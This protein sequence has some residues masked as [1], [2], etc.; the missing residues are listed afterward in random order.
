[1]KIKISFLILLL[2]H[3]LGIFSQTNVMIN[4]GKQWSVMISGMGMEPPNRPVTTKISI[5]QGDSVINGVVYKKIYSTLHEDLSDLTLDGCIRQ[6]GKQ[7]FYL[8]LV[9]HKEILYFDFSIEVGD[10]FTLDGIER[11]VVSTGN[12][13]INNTSLKTITLQHGTLKDYWIE[14]IGSTINGIFSNHFIMAGAKE[15]LLCCHKKNT[16]LYI[17]K[18]YNECYIQKLTNIEKPNSEEKIPYIFYD[19]VNKKIIIQGIQEQIFKLEL[20]D[21]SGKKVLISK[22]IS[23]SEKSIDISHLKMIPGTYIYH[24]FNK[25]NQYT[26]KLQIKE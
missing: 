20:F 11:T 23:T 1:M 8:P 24:L 18:D 4:E 26:N 7:V 17:N 2:I 14:G 10:I 6:N 15:L 3:T 16:L 19:Y 22:D 13:T 21:I 12:I 25:A 9:C 5:L